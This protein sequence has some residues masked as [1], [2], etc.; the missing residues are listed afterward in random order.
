MM[1]NLSKEIRF[2][3]K[4]KKIIKGRFL[5]FPVSCFYNLVEVDSG[6]NPTGKIYYANFITESWKFKEQFKHKEITCFSDFMT[7]NSD[8][9]NRKPI[10]FPMFKICKKYHLMGADFIINKASFIKGKWF[11]SLGLLKAWKHT[12]TETVRKH[13]IDDLPEVNLISLLTAYN[14]SV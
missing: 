13:I 12:Q 7:D 9:K 14:H 3:W 4:R 8:L 11:Y 1:Y 10:S 5:L 6:G 2:L